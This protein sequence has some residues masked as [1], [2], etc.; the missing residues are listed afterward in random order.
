MRTKLDLFIRVG[1]N[2]RDLNLG[3]FCY[4]ARVSVTGQD[5]VKD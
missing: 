2:G 1:R 4:T 3:F 5:H